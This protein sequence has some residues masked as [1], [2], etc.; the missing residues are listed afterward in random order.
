[1][2]PCHHNKDATHTSK[3]TVLEAGG[4]DI[5]GG[6]AVATRR[7]GGAAILVLVGAALTQ[8]AR[9]ESAR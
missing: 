7:A 1:M 6:D 4:T 3:L 5:A 9:L 2:S 8:V